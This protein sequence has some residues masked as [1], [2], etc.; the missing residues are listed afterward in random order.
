ME[1]AVELDIDSESPSEVQHELL[2]MKQQLSIFRRW[3]NLKFTDFLLRQVLGGVTSVVLPQPKAPPR[4]PKVPNLD[5]EPNF[6]ELSKK[7]REKGEKSERFAFEREKAR[8]RSR[9]LESLIPKIIDRTKK[10]RYGYDFD[11]FSDIGEPRHIE[12]KTFTGSS[13]FLSAN[14]LR[15]AQSGEHGLRYFFY[16]VTYGRD[17]EPDGCLVYRAADVLGWCA[18]MPQNFMVKAPKGFEKLVQRDVKKTA[19]ERVQR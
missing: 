4:K 17:G 12:V 11:S 2:R 5:F 14:E 19:D 13:F 15:T 7:A 6:E 16:L 9:G 1:L 3:S 18:L 10:P 8:L